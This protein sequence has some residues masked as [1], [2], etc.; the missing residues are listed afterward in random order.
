MGTL[1]PVFVLTLIPPVVA[2]LRHHRNIGAIFVL[3][4]GAA[5]LAIFPPEVLPVTR[6]IYPVA[7]LIALTWASMKSER[8]PKAAKPIAA[9]PQS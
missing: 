7:W 5:G 6:D 1:I 9:A 3:T 8:E 4:L 2:I